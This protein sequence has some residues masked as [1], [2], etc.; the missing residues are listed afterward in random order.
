MSQS[1]GLYVDLKIN[2]SVR[3]GDVVV[4]LRDKPNKT[5]SLI[6]NAP[7]DVKIVIDKVK[8]SVN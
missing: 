3:I 6:I 8:S 2:E 7:K 5:A 4:Y 1:S